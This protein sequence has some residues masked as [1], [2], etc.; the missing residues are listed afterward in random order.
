MKRGSMIYVAFLD[1]RGAFDNVIRAILVKWILEIGLPVSFAR[2][3]VGIYSSVGLVVRILGKIFGRVLTRVCLKQGCPLSLILF[4]VYINDIVHFFKE[5]S[6]PEV[7]INVLKI[8]MLLFD[9]DIALIA[10]L[11]KDIQTLLYIMEEYLDMKWLGLNKGMAE[12]QGKVF[13]LDIKVIL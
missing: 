4:N 9:D 1:A 10:Q 12:N 7:L 11:A 8:C 6:A 5:K 13:N 2:L 3:I